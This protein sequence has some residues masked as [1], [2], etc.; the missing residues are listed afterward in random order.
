MA[1]CYDALW[2]RLKML[3][4]TKKDLMNRTR[5]SYATLAKLTHNK[6]VSMDAIISICMALNCDIGDI[7]HIS[8]Q[9]QIVDQAISEYVKDINDPAIV[10][11]A[12]V[13]YLDEQ[14]IS[15]NDFIKKVG[16]SANTLKR[17]LAEDPCNLSTYRKLFAVVGREIITEIDIS[18]TPNVPV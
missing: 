10:K 17:V 16:I 5:L 4:M 1:V 7:V 2:I 13:M 9:E 14:K 18:Q 12:V 11:K 6:P 15:K 8:T 3:G